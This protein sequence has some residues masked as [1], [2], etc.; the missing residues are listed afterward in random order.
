MSDD[1]FI[2]TTLDLHFDAGGEDPDRYSPTMRRYHRTLWSKELPNGGFFELEDV[3]PDG[4]LLYRA[5]P[6]NI[7]VSS[8][9]IIRTFRTHKGMA[10][11]LSQ[12]PEEERAS[13]S[14]LGYTIGGMMIFPKNQIDGKYTIN[15]ARGRNGQIEDR[16]DLTLECIRRHYAG[17]KES[18]LADVL[19]RYA[20]FFD[21]FV[22]FKGY[23]NFFF[24]Q[25]LVT[26]DYSKIRYFSP[27]GGFG[28]SALL[29][30]VEEYLAYRALT[31]DF[32]NGRNARI[33]EIHGAK[34]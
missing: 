27:F 4:Y 20:H 31:I 15:Q 21:L 29:K 9:T 33:A 3:F 24:L 1:N 12:I 26:D 2:D 6:R 19:E 18:P 30:T 10:G 32:V 5:E 8:D 17:R 11:V 16:F 14:A 28:K 34:N 23:V 22:D 25:D 13:F 7:M